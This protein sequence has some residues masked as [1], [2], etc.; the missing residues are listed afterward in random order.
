[1]R[2]DSEF[3]KLI[4]EEH[5]E[6]KDLINRV[7]SLPENDSTGKEK[8]FN[9]IKSELIPHMRGEE[10]AFYPLLLGIPETKMDAMEAMEEHHIAEISLK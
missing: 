7:K 6:L 3:L 5:E 2:M 10:K 9:Q 1:M 4:R 8:I